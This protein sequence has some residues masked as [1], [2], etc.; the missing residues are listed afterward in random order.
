[1]NTGVT[2][3]IGEEGQLKSIEY[4][5]LDTG[6]KHVINTDTLIIGSGRFPELVF[7][8]V[9]NNEQDGEEDLI[10]N[11][12]P[13]V[14][15]GIELQK[16]PDANR[17]LGLLSNQDVI[18]EYSSAV[19]A[20]NGGRKAAAAIHNA[21][22]GIQFQESSKFITDQTLLQDVSLLNNV[23]ITPRN[24]LTLRKAQKMSSEKFSTGFSAEE[25]RAEADRCLRCGLIC[26][27]KS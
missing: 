19:A 16:K 13:L 21:M 3:V 14:W 10:E 18:S 12:T 15:E 26:Y 17:E 7:I 27:E 22:Y 9:R 24:I 6:V 23:D 8:P 4:I 25:A 2:K 1:Y 11:N 20:I 5:E